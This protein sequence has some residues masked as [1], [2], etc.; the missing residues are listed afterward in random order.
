MLLQYAT[1]F[2]NFLVVLLCYRRNAIIF[3]F[4]FSTAVHFT[5]VDSGAMFCTTTFALLVIF[6]TTIYWYLKRTYFSIDDRTKKIPGL[7]PEWLVGNL[8]NTGM[9]SGQRVFHEVYIMLKEKY[10]DVFSF[11]LGPNYGMVLSRVEHVRHVFAD[12]QTYDQSGETIKMF[13]LLFPKGLIAL[14]GNNWKR[15]A[16]YML[17]MFRRAKIT[18]YLNTIVDCVDR[19]IDKHVAHDDKKIHTDLF[20]Q[21]QQLMLNVIAHIAFDYD[22]EQTSSADQDF[23]QAFND[24]VHY[25]AQV[26]VMALFPR[27][28]CKLYLMMNWKFRNARR[29]L[30]QRVMQ[31]IAKEEQ[32]QQEQHQNSARSNK[33]K[34]LIASLVK[35]MKEESV[36]SAESS[37]TPD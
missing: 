20:I 35:A 33:P 32:N 18:P 21:L 8:R 15:H 9:L 25:G 5:L 13:S 2:N 7:K 17:P 23:R 19:S 14:R 16:R 11:W 22:L 28:L 36:S 1:C 4:L 12:R 3:L 26:L 34:N 24:F 6:F 10:G 31:I 37:L 30:Q 27:W 29:I